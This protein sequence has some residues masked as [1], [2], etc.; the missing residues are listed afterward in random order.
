MSPE[1][2]QENMVPSQIHISMGK[3][4]KA[5]H[6]IKKE[7]IA[8]QAKMIAADAIKYR[9]SDSPMRRGSSTG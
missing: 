6:N 3:E 7:K 5:P 8:S 9:Q 4:K 2:K 1:S